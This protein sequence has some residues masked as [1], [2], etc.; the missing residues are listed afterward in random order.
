MTESQALLILSK[1]RKL[2]ATVRTY[3][4]AA[5]IR[6]E[7][8]A[9]RAYSQQQRLSVDCYNYAA[10]IKLRAER[11]MGNFLALTE[12]NR[13]GEHAHRKTTGRRGSTGAPILKELGIT[14]DESARYQKL[15]RVPEEYFEK[16]VAETNETRE[17]LTTERVL[18]EARGQGFI[19]PPKRVTET[20]VGSDG[21]VNVSFILRL[22][23]DEERQFLEA[24]DDLGE[25][26]TPL[27]FQTVIKA[28]K[29]KGLINEKHQTPGFEA[30]A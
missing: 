6:S 13:G 1:A 22:T 11:K 12:K 17:R 7:A 23:E 3:D 2:M 29:R 16:I 15:A 25:W 4:Q 5:R 9:L 19:S 21:K 24:W 8:E 28:A 26:A 30:Q 14:K 10:E 18:R 20:R 27:I